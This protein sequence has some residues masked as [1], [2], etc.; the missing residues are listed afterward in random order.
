MSI[1]VSAQ[2]PSAYGA[3]AYA[4]NSASMLETVFSGKTLRNFYGSTALFDISNTDYEGEAKFNESVVIRRDPDPTFSDYEKGQTVTFEDAETPAINLNIDQASQFAVKLDSVDKAQTTLKALDKASEAARKKAKLI[5][6]S[7]VFGTA[8][9][10]AD[11]AN[12][13]ATAGA[14]SGNIDLG[15]T[16][17]PLAL[18]S[19]NV[20]AWIVSLSQCLYEQE[21]DLDE[22]GGHLLIPPM[23]S[24]L[25]KTSE[26]KDASITGDGKSMLRNGRLG[27]IDRFTLYVNNRVAVVNDGGT[28]SYQ[29]MAMTKEALTFAMQLEQIDYHE[30]LETTFG[31]G[32]KGLFVWGSK[33]V[34]PK[35]LVTSRVAL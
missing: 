30:K 31:S 3:A 20:V 6:E 2:N 23:V 18:T 9:T 25:I 24:S 17:A 16:L 33:V 15:T 10:G 32:I 4:N 8:Y 35:A 11:A 1:P 14:I 5:I 27:M 26:L 28:F 22:S 12:I 21:V 34:Q 29:V 13:G 19:A 7:Q